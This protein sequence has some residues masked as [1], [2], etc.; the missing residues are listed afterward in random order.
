MMYLKGAIVS[1][2]LNFRKL[3]IVKL[4]QNMIFLAVLG[5]EITS[6]L[7]AAPC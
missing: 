7:L 4:G 1:V 5:F 2:A 6:V 3:G